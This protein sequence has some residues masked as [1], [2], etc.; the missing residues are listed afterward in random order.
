MILANLAS[1]SLGAPERQRLERPTK[2][3]PETRVRRA[4]NPQAK[5]FEALPL[6]DVIEEAGGLEAIAQT[7]WL[8]IEFV[9]IYGTSIEHETERA[10]LLQ[11]GHSQIWLPKSQSL[12]LQSCPARVVVPRWLAERNEID[13]EPISLDDL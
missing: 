12:V 5:K 7:P 3:R 4:G 2:M 1:I 8:R 9:V 6:E 13:A 11:V 10:I